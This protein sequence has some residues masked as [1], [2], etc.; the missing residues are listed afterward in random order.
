MV[1][2]NIFAFTIINNFSSAA[3]GDEIQMI[4]PE[5]IT[6]TEPM[7]GYYP[8]TYG[9]ENDLIGT[10]PI[11]WNIDETGGTVQVYPDLG[12][13]KKVV[14][15][16][17]NDVGNYAAISNEFDS[18][19]VSGTVEFWVRTE[20]TID[21]TIM[22]VYNNPVTTTHIYTVIADNKFQYY[23]G[24]WHDIASASTSTW[25]HIRIDFE[26]GSGGYQGLSADSFYFY[27]DGVQYGS[28]SFNGGS[29]DDLGVIGFQTSPWAIGVTSY[30][31]AV[32]YSWDPDYNIGDNFNEGLLL[33][34]TT[35]EQLN[36]MGYSLDGQANK[37]ILGNITIPLPSDG[38]HTIQV[39]GNNSLGAYFESDI[40][41]FSS[42]HINI[43][44]PDEITYTG[45]DEGNYPG[46]YGFENDEDGSDPSGWTVDETGGTVNVIAEIGGH[47]KV[48]E[49]H[50]T[51]ASDLISLRKD[52]STTH[53]SGTVEFY[54]RDSNIGLSV[55][56]VLR[57]SS[58]TQSVVMMM[59][60]GYFRYND[61]AWNSIVS[62]SS[63]IWYHVRIDF[64]CGS[65]GYEGL[66]AD[67]YY[68]YINGIKYG[69]YNFQ[70]SISSNTYFY[71]QT[72]GGHDNYYGYI[73][74]I[75]YSWDPNYNIGDNLVDT[76]K[77]IIGYY[78]STYGF[79]NDDM[80][81]NP[82]DWIISGT[83]ENGTIT[84][85]SEWQNH[86]KVL[87][88]KDT[89][90]S[91]APLCSNIFTSGQNTGFVE[92][93]MAAISISGY[94]GGIV[95]LN[96]NIE[97]SI[98][99]LF[100]DGQIKYHDGIRH[101]L[102]VYSVNTWYHVRIEFN[103]SSDTY[104]IY[105]NDLLAENDASFWY[106]ATTMN[107]FG[108]AG[109]TASQFAVYLDAVGYSWDPIYNIGDN[110]NEGLLLSYTN[111]TQLEWIGY[112]LDGQTNKTILGN[113]TIPVPEDG[114]HT[115]QLFGNNTA[116]R[117]YSSDIRQ[118]IVD[119]LAPE[120]LTPPDTYYFEGETGNYISWKAI[121]KNP[122]IYVIRL[123]GSIMVAGTWTSDTVYQ[124]NIDGLTPG[125]YIYEFEVSDQG[126]YITFDTVTVK[127][128]P[129]EEPSIPFGF[130]WIFF[131]IIS[132][133]SLCFHVK[134]KL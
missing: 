134:K 131:S 90:S 126:G 73:D 69:A 66:S 61:G 133:I 102:Q 37:T 52:F 84:V 14:R 54:C 51:S 46:T 104:D 86:K 100:E 38:Q 18:N 110:L 28:Y 39:Y 36:W 62:A 15:L 78:P 49:M 92:F 123:N 68:V 111:T 75:G 85:M 31:D 13:H 6:Y 1:L 77:D 42:Y 120:L 30:V 122:A 107:I 74:A 21:H 98:Y 16:F 24:L 83:P 97:T 124:V 9:F 19:Q 53:E 34:F 63:N 47:K 17:D 27:I 116:G 23:D 44:T 95:V 71:S 10:H 25:Y 33:S 79:E 35:T 76:N 112:S 106:E 88:Y 55:Y 114:P 56:F 11:G 105:I 29:A 5:N 129:I 2:F 12:N 125:T 117:Y 48:V 70:D 64:E 103:C 99:I 121:D 109:S 67:T 80:G 20:N 108:V 94:S 89:S 115:I 58:N 127:V 4:T 72:S 32:G 87:E 22:A 81:S 43:L 96:Q 91:G 3:P 118:F 57:D 128:F 50:D 7:T 26:C 41:D 82:Q 101:N 60:G 113:T 40:K 8:A 65:G 130:M 93:Y 132:I 119:F 45:A 59:T